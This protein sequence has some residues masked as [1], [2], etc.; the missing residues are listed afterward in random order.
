MAC[1]ARLDISRRQPETPR[2]APRRPP[3]QGDRDKNL[4]RPHSPEPSDTW[5]GAESWYFERGRIE[6]GDLEHAECC[7]KILTGYCFILNFSFAA[8]RKHALFHSCEEGLGYFFRRCSLFRQHSAF[9]RVNQMLSHLCLRPCSLARVTVKPFGGCGLMFVAY[10]VPILGWLLRGLLSLTLP[11]HAARSRQ[12]IVLS[13]LNPH[14][15]VLH[16]DA[17]CIGSKASP[18]VN[19]ALTGISPDS[20]E[21]APKIGPIWRYWPG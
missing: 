8:R 11:F 15:G 6:A 14:S 17:T 18:N 5:D 16:H 7:D 3:N 19:P 10:K 13:S 1:E 20:R 12:F 4:T 2:H 9:H 21:L